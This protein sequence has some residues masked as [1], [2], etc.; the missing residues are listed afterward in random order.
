M[1][2]FDVFRWCVMI[3]VKH[4]DALDFVDKS[5]A[6]GVNEHVAKYQARQFESV[7]DIAINTIRID[8]ESRE[9]ATRQDVKDLEVATKGMGIAL[10][11]N[12]KDLEVELKQEIKDVEIGLKQDIKNLKVEL[13]QDIKDVEVGLKQDI[14][15]LEAATKKDIMGLELK[16]EQIK[17][18]V[19]KSKTELIIWVGGMMTTLLLLS[20]IL[21]HFF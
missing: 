1:D 16:I 21:Q 14:K 19:H 10:K 17:V 3:S 4:F 15:D 8:I 9:L 5:K 20:G 18:E 2:I 7:I 6:L 11:Q 12:I 13:K